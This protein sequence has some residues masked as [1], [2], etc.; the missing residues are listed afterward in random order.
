MIVPVCQQGEAQQAFRPR[1]ANHMPE[2]CAADAFA[3]MLRQHDKIL[4][5]RG[6][7]AFGRA[8]GVEQAR[9]GDDAFAFAGN[10]DAADARIREDRL[11]RAALLAAVG[12]ELGLLAEKN[13]EQRT[14]LFD[15]GGPGGLENRG[16][17]LFSRR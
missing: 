9:H 7:A 2:Q 3:A 1:L 6:P 13:P 11:Q 14:E 17:S 10:E 8:H 12:D 15:V 5:K 16:L 4:E